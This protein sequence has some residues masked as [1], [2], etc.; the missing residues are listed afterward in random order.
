MRVLTEG[1][2]ELVQR[3]L[4]L[5][6]QVDVVPQQLHINLFAVLMQRRQRKLQTSGSEGSKVTG[7]AA[8]PRATAASLTWTPRLQCSEVRMRP[9]R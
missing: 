1:P 3:V 2:P 6:V 7:G 4:V 5:L 9:G 8:S